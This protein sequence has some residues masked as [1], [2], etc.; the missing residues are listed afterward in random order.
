MTCYGV[1]EESQEEAGWNERDDLRGNWG[2]EWARVLCGGSLPS[3]CKIN[4][5]L[6]TRVK[7][8]EG[9]SRIGKTVVWS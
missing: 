8:W 4:S 3:R 6:I 1:G 9:M 5:L 7:K 2:R